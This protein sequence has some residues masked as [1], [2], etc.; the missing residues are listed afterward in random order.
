MMTERRLSADELVK[1]VQGG[2]IWPALQAV[3]CRRSG[4][5]V[6]AEVLAR[7]TGPQGENIPPDIFI[8]AIVRHGLEAALLLSLMSTVRATLVPALRGK[9][10]EFTVGFNVSPGMLTS[11][12]VQSACCMFLSGISKSD[13]R[14][15]LEITEDRPITADLIPY[16]R[17]LRK[18]GVRLVLDDFGKGYALP[19]VLAFLP[20]DVVKTDRS[21]T[22][23]AGK[24][25]P[26][27][28]LEKIIRAIQSLSGAEILAEGVEEP[29]ELA[30][31]TRRDI[32]LF[33]GYLFRRP[34]R[35]GDFVKALLSGAL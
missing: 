23:L 25:D 5:T 26:D 17:R 9:G 12:A 16:A 1:A 15:A 8:P 4:R 34:L 28:R 29:E 32:R 33:Q 22:A 35:C 20:L 21:L 10:L 3:C 11:A 6:G 7:W 31:L 24:G 18:T 14:L 27:G 30:W 19:D 13:V 2:D